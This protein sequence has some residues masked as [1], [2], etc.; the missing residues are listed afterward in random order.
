LWSFH[1]TVAAINNAVF[2]RRDVTEGRSGLP[3]TLAMTIVNAAAGC[4]AVSGAN[5]EI[6]QC[7]R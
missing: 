7:E 4:A 2:F 3:V 6:W 1:C 5:V